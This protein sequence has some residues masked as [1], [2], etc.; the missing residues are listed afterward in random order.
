MRG[1]TMRSN[2][3]QTSR[4]R[5]VRAIPTGDDQRARARVRPAE[6]VRGDADVLA[7]IGQSDRVDRQR[8]CERENHTANDGDATWACGRAVPDQNRK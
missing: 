3:K 7:V 2:A 8:A 6:F 4:V 1:M 5:A